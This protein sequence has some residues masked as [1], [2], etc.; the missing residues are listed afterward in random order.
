MSVVIAVVMAGL[1]AMVAVSQF[2]VDRW[3]PSISGIAMGAVLSYFGLRT[4]VLRFFLLSLVSLLAGGGVV[5][6][7][8]VGSTGLGAFYALTGACIVFSGAC[9]L[10]NYLRSHPDTT[11]QNNEP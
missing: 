8:M 10:V 3:L 1:V 6:A 4:G 9:A 5:L 7:G 11:E 2:D